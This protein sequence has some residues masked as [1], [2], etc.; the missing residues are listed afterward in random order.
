[1]G[2]RPR[3]PLVP[4]EDVERM[5]LRAA[6]AFRPSAPITTRALFAGRADE[7][8]KVIDAVAHAGQHAAIYGDRGVGKTSLAYVLQPT[9]IALG[10]HHLFTKVNCD[11][12]DDFTSVW[13][14]AAQEL[15]PAST[16]GLSID[17]Q[18]KLPEIKNVA[19][20]LGEQDALRPDF[21][22]RQLQRLPSTVLIFDE[23]D[24]VALDPT[25][26]FA[27]LIK[28]LSDYVVNTTIV[29][30]GVADKVDELILNHR[31]V[32]RALVQ[33]RMPRM[34]KDELMEAL[35]L[36]SASIGVTFD[37]RVA[38]RIVRLS[39]GLPHYVHSL[40]L[41][42]VRAAVN[43]GRLNIQPRDLEDAYVAATQNASLT[44]HEE[45]ERAVSS[46]RKDALY[47]HVLLACALTDKNDV[48]FRAADVRKP[49]KAIAGRFID[50]PQFAAH[51]NGFCSP[52][53]GPVLLKE[54][55][56]R[57]YKSRF[58]DPL[59]EPYV[60]LNGLADGMIASSTLV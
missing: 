20:A 8:R 30:V 7:I 11:S 40:G 34:S 18:A 35:E 57:N 2:T 21:I 13:K 14:K 24:R 46:S 55:G 26:I 39:Q 56:E 33:V 17:V 44:L 6:E 23:F 53:R 59:L 45:Y 16:F 60:V 5:Y 49:L 9:L 42:S 1:M 22:R 3:N 41:H 47:R 4:G 15:V 36:A 52:E 51:L 43:E 19:Q 27:D 25:I 10:S 50:I 31:S 32:E 12:A 58:V 37:P 54:G 48:W 29:I 38:G 28:M